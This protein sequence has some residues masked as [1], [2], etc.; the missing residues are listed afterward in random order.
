MAFTEQQ[1]QRYARHIILPEVGAKGQEK[2]FRSKVLVVGAGGL[3]S[4]NLLYLAAA[5]VGTIGVIDDDDVDLS[6]LQRQIVHPTGRIGEPKVESAAKTLAE[7][8]PEVRV[9]R[10][11]MRLN[12]ENAL[13][14]FADYDLIADGSDNFPTR[15]LVNDASYFAK[16][17]LVTAAVLRFDGQLA[18]FRAYTAGNHPCYRCIFREP[19]PAGTVPNCAEGG[20]FGAIAGVMGTLQATEV[21]KELLGIGQSLDG[22]MLIYDGLGS[23]FRK[24][25]VK[26]DKG[27]PLCG[28]APTLRTLEA[29]AAMCTV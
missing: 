20:V 10:H 3:G 19:P 13:G 22:F 4:P 2:L 21:V 6:N 28:E 8:N 25:A 26:R 27:C 15:F 17:P 1:I 23:T 12:V 24:I 5:G 7:I 16:K 11:R 14:L 29:A 9:V 18:T